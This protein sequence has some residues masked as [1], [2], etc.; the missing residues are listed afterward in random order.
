MEAG[1]DADARAPNG[2]TTPL[3]AAARY[4]ADIILDRRD[5][6]EARA[7]RRSEVR[8]EFADA[9]GAGGQDAARAAALD[10]LD[11]YDDYDPYR[12]DSD[13]DYQDRPTAVVFDNPSSIYGRNPSGVMPPRGCTLAAAN[14]PV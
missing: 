2:Y 6:R 4:A 9:R 5:E 10:V 12:D 8:G 1:A 11:A 14:R 7:Y 3:E 13:D